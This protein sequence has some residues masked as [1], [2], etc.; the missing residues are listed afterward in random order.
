MHRIK[1]PALKTI[2]GHHHSQMN[3]AM[4]KAAGQ[5]QSS[6]FH[7]MYLDPRVAGLVL[8]QEYRERIFNKHRCRSDTQNSCMPALEGPGPRV[9]QVGFHQEPSAMTKQ[10]FPFRR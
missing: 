6:V 2:V 10:V 4:L 8:A 3:I 7:K 9:K 5:T 1:E